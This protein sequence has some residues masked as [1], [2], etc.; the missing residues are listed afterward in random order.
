MHALEVFKDGLNAPE[1]ATGENGGFLCF[2]GGQRRVNGGLGKWVARF[3]GWPSADHANGVPSKKCDYAEYSY[4]P[5]DCGTAHVF[6]PG[7]IRP[8]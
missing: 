8:T 6:A 4:G 3:G 5:A 2:A 7:E 1:A